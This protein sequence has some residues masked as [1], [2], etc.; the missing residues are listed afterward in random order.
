MVDQARLE[1]VESG[2]VPV[3]PGWFVVNAGE[4]AWVHNEEAQGVCMFESDEFFLR[5]R[6]DLTEYVKPEA[7]FAL[8]VLK[9]GRPSG[10]Y[11]A[12]S[13]QEDFLVLLGE[14]V[15]IIEE[16]E[17]LVRAWDFVHCPPGTGHA[18]VGAGDGPCVL[19]CAGSRDF[20]DDNF[21]VCP[22][23]RR[24]RAATARVSS[25][26]LPGTRSRRDRRVSG[27]WSGLIAGKSCR[28]A[29]SRLTD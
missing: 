3:S 14:C 17:R 11:H 6:P 18:F 20:N 16:E 5:G 10:M 23:A 19:V 1:K 7:G 27:E 15:L 12:E 4:A 28:G 8:R 29:S 9:P 22:G 26:T 21:G 13:V 25:G 24:S 2:L